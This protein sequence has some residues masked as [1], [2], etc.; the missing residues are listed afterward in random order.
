[1]RVSLA[2][3]AY[4]GDCRALLVHKGLVKKISQYHSLV[5]EQ[6]R[7]GLLTEDQARTHAQRNVIT[8]SLGTQV[9]VDIDVF[10]EQLQEGDTLILCSDGLSGLVSDEELQ[11]IVD[12]FV[13]QE[14]V[15]HLVE[16]ANANGGPDNITAI[17]VRVQEVGEE[18]PSVRYPVVVGGR[19]MGEDTVTLGMFSDTPLGAGSSNGGIGISSGPLRY[20]SGPLITSPDSIT[21][22]QPVIGKHQSSRRR[23]FYPTLA[24]VALLVMALIGGGA[25]YFFRS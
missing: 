12:Q 9:E 13:P 18:P 3:I 5:Y 7:A 14:S 6:V 4:V 15:Y 11:R 17:V 1:M 2:F 19:E 21:A 25:F 20:S 23:L 10:H 8:R 16:R 22:P 24:L